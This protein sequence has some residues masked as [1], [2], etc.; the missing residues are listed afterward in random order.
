MNWTQSHSPET[1]HQIVQD[2]AEKYGKRPA[3]VC[4]DKTIS[5]AQFQEAVKKLASFLRAK[6]VQPGDRIAVVLSNSWHF[7]VAAFAVILADAIMVPLDLRIRPDNFLFTAQDCGATGLIVE[8]SAFSKLESILGK[9]DPI[10]LIIVKD[11]PEASSRSTY[12]FETI[13][14]QKAESFGEISARPMTS[15]QAVSINYTSGST[16][17]PKG[18]VHSHKSWIHGAAFTAQYFE[19]S[20][21]DKIMIPFPLHHAYAFRHILAYLIAGGTCVI[22]RDLTHALKTVIAE[23]P[24]ALLLVPDAASIILRFYKKVLTE[25]CTFLDLVSVGTAALPDSQLIEIQKALPNTKIHIPYGLTEARIGFLRV[26]AD[27]HERH[28]TAVAP[29]LQLKVINGHGKPLKRGE[30]GEIIVSGEGLALGYWDPTEFKICKVQKGGL[31]TGDLGRIGEN[32]EIALLGRK[33]DIINVGGRK[34]DPL[35][36]ERVLNEHPLVFECAVI[37]TQDLRDMIVHGLKGIVVLKNGAKV[38][39]EELIQ[40]CKRYLE[41]YK[42]PGSIDFRSSLPKSSLGKVARKESART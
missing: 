17:R 28:I 7:V 16:G 40:H 39:E 41:P 22:C 1:F 35:E 3:F 11:G 4:E 18:V 29:A 24:N 21:R 31:P 33:D 5:Y 20:I 37:S 26:D 9:L 38:A 32:R 13:L 25:C 27:S 19:L 36:V 10:N 12:S 6:G 15:A 23:K 14:R 34:V 2:G 30:T 42:I 8:D